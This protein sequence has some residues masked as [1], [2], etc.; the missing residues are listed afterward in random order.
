MCLLYTAKTVV[1]NL[2]PVVSISSFK[3]LN[4]LWCYNLHKRFKVTQHSV[5]LLTPNQINVKSK[6]TLRPGDVAPILTP[7]VSKNLTPCFCSVCFKKV[8]LIDGPSTILRI[9]SRKIFSVCKN[10]NALLM[11]YFLYA[12]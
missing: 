6:T 8:V 2:T 9:I 5:E 3:K 11:R 12:M 10:N 4:A 7:N 1:L